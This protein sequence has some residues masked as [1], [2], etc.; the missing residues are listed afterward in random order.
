MVKLILLS[1]AIAMVSSES[2]ETTTSKTTTT[3]IAIRMDKPKG[4]PQPLN[5]RVNVTTGNAKDEKV[6]RAA[7]LNF[8]GMSM[9]IPSQM[10]RTFEK[11]SLHNIL[12]NSIPSG[13]KDPDLLAS[14]IV[15]NFYFLPHLESVLS[16]DG[17]LVRKNFVKNKVGGGNRRISFSRH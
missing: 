9:L 6:K 1:L 15:N 17:N 14:E 11:F 7:N 3:V 2:N 13:N 12:S 8:H 5:V 10:I 16:K 4:V